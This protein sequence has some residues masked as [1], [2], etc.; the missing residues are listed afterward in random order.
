VPKAKNMF[1]NRKINIKNYRLNKILGHDF[2]ILDDASDL[3]GH[4]NT[5][6]S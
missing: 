1:I 3:P 5:W 4:R 2:P 6:A